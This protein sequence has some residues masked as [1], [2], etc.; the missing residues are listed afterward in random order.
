MPSVSRVVNHILPL[1]RR[2]VRRYRGP[3]RRPEGYF[4]SIDVSWTRPHVM[5]YEYIGPYNDGLFEDPRKHHRSVIDNSIK[6]WGKFRP[7]HQIRELH[8]PNPGIHI[9]PEAP[10]NPYPPPPGG[11]DSKSNDRMDL[12][13]EGTIDTESDPALEVEYETKRRPQFKSSGT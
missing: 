6:K 5:P 9:P 12:S 7:E 3:G 13:D 4:H 2:K 10:Y 8:Y 1:A 11:G